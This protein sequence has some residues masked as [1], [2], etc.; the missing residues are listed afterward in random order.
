MLTILSIFGTRPEAVK[1]AP[2]LKAFAQRPDAIRSVVCSTGQ[3]REMLA[4]VLDLFAIRPDI[5]LDIMEPDQNLAQV[6]ATLLAGLDAVV[7]RVRPDWILAVGD[8]TTVFAAAMVAHFRRVQ[9][10]HVEAGL[11]TGDKWHPFPEEVFRR[12]ADFVADAY[13]APT[14]R[15]RQVLLRE[16]CPPEH[17]YLT[18]NPVVDALLD[19]AARPYDWSQGPLAGLPPESRIVFI[20]AHRR[21]SFGQPFRDLCLAIRDLAERFAAEGVQFVYPVHLNPHVQK[22]VYELLADAPNVH[23]LP[24]LDYRSL[25]QA[26][27]RATLVLTDSGGIQ[28]EAPTFGVPVLVM[29]QATERPEGIEANVARLVGTSR[30]R[31]VSEA[32]RLLRDPEAHTA[33]ARGVNPYGDGQAA[34]RILAILLERGAR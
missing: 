34:G 31:I 21:E 5:S 18:G 1:M 27:K 20:T 22:P 16:G 15:A 6:S 23:L 4:Q 7:E 24:P 11:R 33:M 32:E 29:R 25:V 9:F 26:L 14:E 19:V 30:E 3:H 28:E 17:V 2:L 10:G 13:F 8:T 12:V